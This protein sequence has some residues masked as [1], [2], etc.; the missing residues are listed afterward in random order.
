MQVMHEYEW[1]T[2]RWGLV[3]I[4]VHGV[5]GRH[6]QLLRVG[7]WIMEVDVLHEIEQRQYMYNIE[8]LI[9]MDQFRRVIV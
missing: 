4:V 8:M 7:I 6:L 1:Q 9:E 3:V 2:E 5:L